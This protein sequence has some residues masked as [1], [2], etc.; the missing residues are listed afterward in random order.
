MAE[1]NISGASLI[2][3]GAGA[4]V[5]GF[6]LIAFHLAADLVFLSNEKPPFSQPIP[7]IP[8]AANIIGVIVLIIG[9]LLMA[10]PLLPLRRPA[11]GIAQDRARQI[12]AKLENEKDEAFFEHV[13]DNVEWTVIGPRSKNIHFHKKSEARARVTPLTAQHRLGSQL[14]V[15][16][17]IVEA[18]RSA[19]EL[20]VMPHASHAKSQPHRCCWILFF[21]EGTV[22]RVH[23]YDHGPLPHDEPKKDPSSRGK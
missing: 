19:V 22:I 20:S 1:S 2:R 21:E 7:E 4:M 3:W 16:Q 18:N 9:A 12:I 6:L 23:E 11:A 17:V 8:G 15:G 5:A 14:K 10:I 13:A